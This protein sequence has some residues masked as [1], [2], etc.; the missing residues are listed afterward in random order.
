MYEQR[1]SS[2]K[3]VQIADDQCNKA[4]HAHNMIPFVQLDVGPS[5][6]DENFDQVC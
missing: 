1:S 3:E 4:R 2:C 5:T 6:N